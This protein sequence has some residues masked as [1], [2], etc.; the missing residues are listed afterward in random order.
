MPF[1]KCVQTSGTMFLLRLDV[2]LKSVYVL[3]SLFFC[4]VEVFLPLL[5]LPGV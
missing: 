3:R 4:L 5:W 2:H 1:E